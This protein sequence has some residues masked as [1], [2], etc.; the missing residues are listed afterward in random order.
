MKK[1]SKIYRKSIPLLLGVMA[2]FAFNSCK[3]EVVKVGEEKEASY[4][5]NPNALAT[6]IGQNGKSDQ[7]LFEFKT[8]GEFG[9]YVELTKPSAAAIN[10]SVAINEEVLQAYNSKN[11]TSFKMFPKELISLVDQGKFSINANE[12]KSSEIKIRLTSNQQL[13]ESETFAIPLSTKLADGQSIDYL[14]LVKD[15]SKLPNADKSTGI[16][17]ISCMEVNDTNPLNNLSIT[18]KNSGKPLVDMVILFS[19][20]I[21]YSEQLGKVIITHNPNVTHIL[22]NKEKYLK[23]LKDRGIKVILSILGN[24][25]KSGVANLNGEA[26]KAF[27]QEIAATCKAYDLDGVFFDDEYSSYY[28][29]NIPAGFVYPSAKAA[30]NLCYETKKAMPDKLIMVYVYSRTGNFGGSNAI[31]EA[32]AGA[33]VDYA[34][35]D[36]LGSYSLTNAYPGLAR[37]GWGM[38]SGEYAQG[39]FP[40]T[41]ALNNIRTGG[42]GAHMIFAFDP[43]RA[44]FTSR[45]KPALENIAKILFDDELVYDP[46]KKYAKDW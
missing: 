18:L 10:N 40:T 8:A 37:S 24:H 33:Y 27:A 21:N 13:S 34:L 25:D 7:S 2:L 35:H 19:S 5:T 42:Y 36:Y 39:R 31:A 12:K 23:P 20:N 6:L 1:V 45:Q 43:N 22:E 29:S 15:V 32:P 14:L 44:N 46:A 41:T 3:E 28:F 4:E 38:S 16:K 9:L 11:E 26:A 17:I 30:A